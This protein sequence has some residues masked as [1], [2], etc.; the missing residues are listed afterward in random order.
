M[1]DAFCSPGS[2]VSSSVPS[3]NVVLVP[4]AVPEARNDGVTIAVSRMLVPI[5]VDVSNGASRI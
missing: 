4:V 1:P 3:W 2:A 5:V